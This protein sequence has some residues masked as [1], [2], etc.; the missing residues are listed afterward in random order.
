MRM[1]IFLVVEEVPSVLGHENSIQ[2]L[3][4]RSQLMFSTV[5][6]HQVVHGDGTG[7]PR[8]AQSYLRGVQ[9]PGN[10]L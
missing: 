1:A 7:D 4:S 10:E 6:L 5:M 9:W 3:V 2:S 8:G